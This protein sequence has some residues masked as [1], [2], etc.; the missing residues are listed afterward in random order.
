M[1]LPNAGDDLQAIK[2]GVMELADLVVINKADIDP[3]AATRAEA[4]ITSALR[5]FSSHGKDASAID[6]WHTRAMQISALKG[7]GIETFWA[8]V[9]R[10]HHLRQA[11]GEFDTRRRQQALAWMWDI[12]H[13]R[14]R[15]D[16]HQHPDVRSA[17]AQTLREVSEARIAPSSAARILLN[18]FEHNAN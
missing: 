1:L 7:Q 17:L 4:Q 14:L 3:A 2:R 10:F 8:H 9:E 13:A 11:S 6:R 12:V 15:T 18:L 5:I 16:F